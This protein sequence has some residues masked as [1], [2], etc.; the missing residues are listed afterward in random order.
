MYVISTIKRNNPYQQAGD[1][2]GEKSV[3][4]GIDTSVEYRDIEKGRTALSQEMFKEAG[5]IIPQYGIDLI[6]I[7]IRQIKYSNEL[8]PSV[9]GRMI[10]ERNQM[11]ADPE[12]H[13]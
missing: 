9:Y 11:G 6:D 7:L 2:K 3:A 8:T 12:L 4:L 1:D 10:K 13:I 5:Q